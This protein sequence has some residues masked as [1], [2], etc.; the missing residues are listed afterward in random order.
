MAP[1]LLCTAGISLVQTEG[2]FSYC[3]AGEDAVTQKWVVSATLVEPG[4]LSELENPQ[5]AITAWDT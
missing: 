2:S 5:T 4:N 1:S 3:Q